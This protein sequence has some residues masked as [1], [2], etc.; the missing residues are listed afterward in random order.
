MAGKVLDDTAVFTCDKGIGVSFAVLQTQMKAKEHGR[1]YLNTNTKCILKIPGQCIL[2]PNPS[3]AGFLPCSQ[4]RIPA[5]VWQGADKVI[6][7]D[8]AK[9]L[10]MQ[11]STMCPLGGRIC[12]QGPCYTIFKTGCFISIARK[13]ITKTDESRAHKEQEKLE[14]GRKE[15]NLSAR[16][17]KY[18]INS[19]NNREREQMISNVNAKYARCP[20]E[21]CRERD[22]CAYF[23][24]KAGIEN[25]SAELKKRF[26]TDRQ[27]E[28][29][30]YKSLH[31]KA[32]SEFPK[33][34]W[35]Y[36]GHHLISGNQ[37]FMAVEKKSGC[38]KY[39][40]LLMLANM[41]EYDINNA[42]NCILLPSIAR[43]EGPWG[44]LELFEKAA[45]AFDVMDI[46]KRQ[47]HLGG[48]AYTIPK[49]S[50][51]YYKPTG[52]QVLMSGTGEYF[53]NYAASVQSKLNQ[54][55]ERYSRKRCWNKL[56]TPE[57]RN[58]FVKEL[59][60]TSYEIEQM[61]LKFA[62]RPKDSYPYF[63]SKVSVDYAY[64][65]PKTGKLMILYN[66]KGEIYASKFR[67]SRKQKNGYAVVIM[68]NEEQ[69]YLKITK[70]GLH[71]FVRYSENIMHF[72]ID[73]RMK[74]CLPWV[75]TDEY[76]NKRIIDGDDVYQFACQNASELF[77]FIDKNEIPNQGQL[78][79]IRKRWREVKENGGICGPGIW[80]D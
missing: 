30:A 34:G 57:F 11:A 55:N 20:Y 67:I 14:A 42:N 73:S 56:N 49:D 36:E 8:G 16:I 44:T 31:K 65:A 69:P 32:R 17:Q 19:Q 9:V 53:P 18:D 5:T 48:H 6:S 7:I 45:K 68:P 15:K 27:E 43:R 35:G 61:L 46:M 21:I 59:D 75:C 24:A 64:D 38:L 62:A 50:L 28:D 13:Q 51:K 66:K 79:R 71:E 40:H 3:G 60:R 1:K 52:R 78:A 47:W 26:E 10:T 41:C 74:F 2:Q 72:W 4:V 77:T 39:G 33:Y 22:A 12:L 25:N 54:L 76:I 70:D 58:R 29:A 23:N 63:V 80:K 37:V